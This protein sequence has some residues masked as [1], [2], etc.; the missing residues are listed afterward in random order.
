MKSF[1]GKAGNGDT[2]FAHTSRAAGPPRADKVVVPLV[3]K[4]RSFIVLTTQRTGSSWLMDRLNNSPELEGHM[5]LFY[6]APRREPPRAGCND[7]PRFVE[8]R[9]SHAR[10]LRPAATFRYLNEF[11]SRRTAVGFKLMYSQLREYP[12]ILPWLVGKRLPIVHL[13]RANHLDVVI[14]ERLANAVGTS[15]ATVEEG[16]AGPV[17]L[18]LDPIDT[19][20][21]VRGL[22]RKQRVMRRMLRLLPNPCL[23]VTYEELLDDREG[24]GPLYRFLRINPELMSP[25]SRLVKRQRERH[26]DVIENWR[27]VREA[28]LRAGYAALVN[29]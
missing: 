26:E 14:S 23:E 5:E 10:G 20:R 12:E 21:R 25:G 1:E 9:G 11:Y 2:G 4:A 8:S 6:L 13:V 15:H 18:R 7:Y 3:S 29:E 27:A 28:L 19:V 22:E 16:G 24:F 17:H